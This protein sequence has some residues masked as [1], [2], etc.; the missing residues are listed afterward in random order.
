M[1]I[2]GGSENANFYSFRQW[3]GTSKRSTKSGLGVYKAG[4]EGA[5]YYRGALS[6]DAIG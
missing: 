4:G 6:G 1:F 2:S 5:A 3:N